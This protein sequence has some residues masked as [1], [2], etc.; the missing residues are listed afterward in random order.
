[1]PPARKSIERQIIDYDPRRPA[2][3]FRTTRKERRAVAMSYK[4]PASVRWPNGLAPTLARVAPAPRS[5]NPLP[6]ADWVIVTWT[7]AEAVMLAQLMTPGL[8]L[9]GWTLYASNWEAFAP[10]IT[11]VRAP[12]LDIRSRYYKK[13]GTYCL[14]TV[15]KEKVLCFKS[16]LHLDTDGK[17]LPLLKLWAQ[18]IKETGAKW[19]VT[20]GT[21]GVIGKSIRLGDV[22]V[23]HATYADM[24]SQFKS[25]SFAGQSYSCTALSAGQTRRVNA[26]GPM[27]S[28]NAGRLKP[29]RRGKAA[30]SVYAPNGMIKRPTVV[31]TDIFAFDNT[32]DSYGLQRLGNVCEMDDA[33]L[34]YVIQQN[35]LKV[36]WIAIR[37][38]SDPQSDGSLSHRQQEKRAG[39]IYMKYGYWTTIGNVLASWAIIDN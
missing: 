28:V 31:T 21:G 34:G 5:S 6:R 18:I 37:N 12:S 39:Q 35:R 26:L 4:A 7:M 29:E 15:D 1:M 3:E 11:G 24:T 14:I 27:M 9:E 36:N 22:I 8:P 20:T 38:A 33:T 30:P 23:A 32:K 16:N 13:L 2:G 25:Q 10:L 17:H 19:I